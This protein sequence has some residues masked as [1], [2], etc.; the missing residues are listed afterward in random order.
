MSLMFLVV[1]QGFKAGHDVEELF[2][3]AALTEAVEFSVEIL[4]QFFDVLFSSLHRG[5]SASIF[6]GK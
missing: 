2:V 1:R 4:E 5:Q 3:D 6:A